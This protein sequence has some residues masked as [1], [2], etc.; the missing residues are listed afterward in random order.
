MSTE[1]LFPNLRIGSRLG[2]YRLIEL[3]GRGGM[4]EVYQAERADDHYRS[5]VA[6][7]LV[8]VDHDASRVA[9][10]FRSERQILAQLEHPNIA[11]LIDGGATEEGVPYLVMELIAGQSIDLY[12]E[13]RHLTVEQRVRLF[14]QV[15]AAVSFAHQRL[16]VHRDLKPGNILVTAEGTV[17]LLDFGIAKLVETEPATQSNGVASDMT[18]T[19]VRVMTMEYA[20]PEQVRGD[21]ITTASDVYSLGVVLYRLLTGRSPYRE[22]NAAERA[23]EILSDSSPSKPSTA[24]NETRVRT[25]D[26][27]T[28]PQAQFARKRVRRALQGD[29]D[30]VLLMALRK[31][32]ERRYVSVDQFAED[33]RHYLDG[34]PVRARG[35]S[36]QYRAS[37]FMS[38]HKYAVT[39]ASLAAL[40]LVAG[41]VT[42]TWQARIAAEQTRIAQEEVRKTR[43][44]QSF[45]TALFEKNTRLQPDAL[46][47]RNMPVHELLVA[48]GDKVMHEFTDAPAVRME[49]MNTVARLLIDINEFDR[50][51]ALSRESVKI[52]RELHLT[53][54]DSYVEALIGVAFAGRLLGR[55]E[56]AGESR[57]EALRVLDARNDRTSLL[58]ARAMGTTIAQFSSDPMREI[59]LMTAAVELFKTRYPHDPGYF[60]SVFALGQLNRTQGDMHAAIKYFQAASEVFK[61]SGLQA[62]SDLGASYAWAAF[63]EMQLGWVDD[64]LRD[65][66][67]GIVLLRQHAGDVSIYT[68]IHLGLYGQALHQAGKIKQA[69]EYFD[70]VLTPE[71]IASPTAVEFDTAVYKAHGLLE[72]GNAARALAVLE[73]YSKQWLEFGKRFVPNGVQYLAVRAR[74]LAS[75]GKLA[76]AKAE[77]QH[78]AELPPFYGVPAQKADSYI[79]AF[80]AVA[81][82]DNDLP[83]ARGV[84]AQHGPIEVPD[85]FDLDYLQLAI[86]SARLKLRM[87]DVPGAIELADPALAHLQEHGG[88]SNF[89]F[90]R[91]ELQQVRD[92]AGRDAE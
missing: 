78:V 15:C 30:N 59:Q 10:R 44:V 7:K 2:P 17:K 5:R 83:T 76:P 66:E 25:E 19:H 4:G 51:S 36:L 35:D 84:L 27:E 57:D 34:M 23:V 64:A 13:E 41:I 86:D 53:N 29:L 12:C 50:A 3:I 58:R 40:A 28:A 92:T 39:A 48:A 60:N 52:A 38:R 72:E 32:P 79:A 77:L 46:K 6:I 14:L 9:W 61:T 63:C 80:I 18:A 33:L 45:M 67:K 47:A 20:S 89:A 43:A 22:D 73:P 75:Q 16:V 56:E 26:G 31:E 81:L 90:M 87:G 82:A 74:A 85:E 42:T 55:G 88:K 54:S 37:K 24:V 8:R 65:Y 71:H 70:M 62:Y 1:P 21:P 91:R 11:R 68:R 69:H 49:V